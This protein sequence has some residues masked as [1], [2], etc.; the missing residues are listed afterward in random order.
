M[1]I[2]LDII[3]KHPFIRFHV[4]NR[5]YVRCETHYILMLSISVAGFAG[6]QLWAP[7]VLLVATHG[8]R[9][10]KTSSSTTTTTTGARNSRGET[11]MFAD[12]SLVTSLQKEF[13]SEL[14]IMPRV[15]TVDARQ[16]TS[17]DMKALKTVLGEMKQFLCQVGWTVEARG[18]GIRQ[19]NGQS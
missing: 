14:L 2:F 9:S 5:I 4:I 15:C 3:I 10:P 13:G 17:A 6:T 11:D 8:D 1:I 18:V 12:S 7:R 16:P 19:L